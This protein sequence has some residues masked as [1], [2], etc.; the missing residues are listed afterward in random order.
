M[1]TDKH[2]PFV[3][4]PSELIINDDGSIFHLHIKPEHLADKVIICGDPSRVDMIANNFDS[5]EVD[6]TSREFHTITGT[7]KGKRIT[8]LSHGIGGDNIEIVLN[9]LDALANIDFGTRTVRETPK[10]L[11]IVRVGTSGGLQDFTP[12]GS[13]VAAGYAIGFDGVLHFYADEDNVVDHDFEKALRDQLEWNIYGLMPYVVKA[14]DSLLERITKG[15]NIIRGTTIACNGF[16]A[17]QG[18]RLRGR[19]ADP[20]LNRKIEGFEYRGER[21]TNFE[22]ESAALAGIGAILGHEVLTVCTIIAGRKSEE[23][24]TNYKGTIED[25]VRIVLDRI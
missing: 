8:A 1:T 24:N 23:M 13:Y 19:L 6:I 18:R 15:T 11:S 25:L 9:E 21:I 12:I 14:P 4:P 7:Y 16:Y 20:D 17:P 10:S 5:R 2:T 22:M 3:I